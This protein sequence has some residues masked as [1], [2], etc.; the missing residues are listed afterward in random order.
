MPTLASNLGELLRNGFDEQWIAIV[1]IGGGLT[2]AL[3]SILAGTLK[4][5]LATRA[6]EQSRREITAYVA[7]GSISPADAAKLLEA[8]RPAWERH[9]AGC[10]WNW[11]WSCGGGKA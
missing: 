3:V 9:N 7:E 6:R 1:A 4:S 5:I 11:G 10:G 8:G 2:I